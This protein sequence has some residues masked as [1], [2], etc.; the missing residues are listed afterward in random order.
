MPPVFE[1]I[2]VFSEYLIIMEV[3]F[4][5]S[6]FILSESRKKQQPQK[7]IPGYSGKEKNYKAGYFTDFK[8]KHN[9]CQQ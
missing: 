7:N 4:V 9:D 6:W 8:P 5:R 2:A 3:C 1:I